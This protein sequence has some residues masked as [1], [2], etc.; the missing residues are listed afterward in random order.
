[1]QGR[2]RS[3]QRD[4]SPSD[5]ASLGSGL[6]IAVHCLSNKRLAFQPLNGLGNE[7]TMHR[8]ILNLRSAFIRHGARHQ[9][10]GR[11][12][13]QTTDSERKLPATCASGVFVIACQS[14]RSQEGKVVSLHELRN[15][16]TL[17]VC[18]CVC[19]C[20]CVCGGGEVEEAVSSTGW[21]R[22]SGVGQFVPPQPA[23]MLSSGVST[24]APSPR[25]L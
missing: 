15:N 4:H 22:K 9:P 11:E 10:R 19:V 16:T 24:R 20:V 3:N 14:I 6:A 23:Q 12:E 7:P 21:I 13:I 1:M 25:W 2:S 18:A 17:C 8:P 5:G